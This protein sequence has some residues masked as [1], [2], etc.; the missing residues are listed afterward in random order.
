SE[1]LLPLGYISAVLTTI[2]F[3][4]GDFF[5]YMIYPLIDIYVYVARWLEGLAFSSVEVHKPGTLITY[6]VTV[7][8]FAL[9][10]FIPIKRTDNYDSRTTEERLAK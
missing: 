4:L 8:I 1:L 7:G 6:I 3:P 9:F 2:F 10:A 5:S